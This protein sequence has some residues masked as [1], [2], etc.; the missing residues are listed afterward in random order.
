[1]IISNLKKTVQVKLVK[2]SFASKDFFRL[3]INL[4]PVFKKCVGGDRDIFWREV[5]LHD[6]GL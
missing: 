4:Q 1:M 6:S 5:E 3:R 2:Q